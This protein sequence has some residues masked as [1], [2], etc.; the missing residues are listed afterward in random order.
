MN[1]VQQHLYYITWLLR[2]CLGIAQSTYAIGKARLWLG[3]SLKGERLG[4]YVVDLGCLGLALDDLKPWQTPQRNNLAARGRD[5]IGKK[6]R[7]RKEEYKQVNLP[8]SYCSFV[9]DHLFHCHRF[10]WL[11][12]FVVISEHLYA[13]DAKQRLKLRSAMPTYS[14]VKEKSQAKNLFAI[15]CKREIFNLFFLFLFVQVQNTLS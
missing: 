1:F 15:V 9:S 8:P 3:E 13:L 12:V 5:H 11:Q 10:Y 7:K 4:L 14:C 2:R 6:I